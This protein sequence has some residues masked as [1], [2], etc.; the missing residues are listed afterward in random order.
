MGQDS[1]GLAPNKR[2]GQ[3]IRASKIWGVGE[4]VGACRG[5]LWGRT[6]ADLRVAPCVRHR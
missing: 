4:A 3:Q 2:M 6:L 5:T 1:R